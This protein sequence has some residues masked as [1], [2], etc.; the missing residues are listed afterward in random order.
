MLR[1]VMLHMCARSCEVLTA[2]WVRRWVR[3]GRY[4]LQNHMME[5]WNMIDFCVPGLLGER[6]EFHAQ[7]V[8]P[9]IEGQVSERH[10]QTYTH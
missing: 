7:F 9:I 5:Y 2:P 8:S 3:D 4:P 10:T 6:G 1:R